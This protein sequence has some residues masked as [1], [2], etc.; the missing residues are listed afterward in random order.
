MLIIGIS[1]SILAG[2]GATLILKQSLAGL[3]ATEMKF[4]SFLISSIFF[5]GVALA[6]THAF[7]RQHDVTWREFFGLPNPYWPRVLGLGCFIGLLV[8]PP[9]LALK[10]V[11]EHAVRA[12]THD[13]TPQVAMQVLQIAVSLPKQICFAFATIFLAPLVE[14]I[15][16]RGIAYKAI[17]D[18]GHPQ[19]AL[20]A[21]AILF[22]I[23][24]LNAPILI[25]IIMLG[26]VLALLY[27]RSGTLLAPIT[28]H[29]TF[30]AVN[31]FLYHFQSSR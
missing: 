14:E 26:V 12:V 22:G 17:R 28:A 7:L 21:S 16:F 4:F 3:R 5:Q 1:I 8:V 29:A 20:A 9:A 2:A 30:N 18:R 6:L 24:H 13:A 19:L 25:P 11:S 27:E 23:I 31:F 10:A 15:L